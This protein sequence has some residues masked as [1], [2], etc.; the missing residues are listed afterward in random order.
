MRD[1]T[2]LNGL[3]NYESVL[4]SLNAGGKLREPLTLVYPKDGLIT[5]DYP[6]LLLNKDRQPQYE[7]LV[8]AL[9]SPDIQRRIMTETQRRPVNPAVTLSS[10]FPVGLNIDL[11]FP[12]SAEAVNAVLTAYLQDTVAARQHHL[13]AR[14]QR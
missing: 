9:K 2:E 10:A 5:A 7:R 11:P 6:L 3:I 13:C 12:G 1:Q 14:H 4:L 8:A